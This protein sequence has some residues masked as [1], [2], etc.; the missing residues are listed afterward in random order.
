MSPNPSPSLPYNA[1]AEAPESQREQI[2]P[3]AVYLTAEGAKL[4][5]VK[6]STIRHAIRCGKI[7]GQGRPFRILGSEL[8]KLC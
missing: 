3:F 8:L 5:R 7:R 1:P 4:V 2:L 6:A